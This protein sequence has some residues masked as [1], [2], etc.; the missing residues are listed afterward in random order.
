[1]LSIALAQAGRPAFKTRTAAETEI[2]DDSARTKGGGGK[3]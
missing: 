1:L 2:E 3:R